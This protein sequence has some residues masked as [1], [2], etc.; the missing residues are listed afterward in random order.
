[1]LNPTKEARLRK[2]YQKV[3]DAMNFMGIHVLEL[4]RHP[5]ATP[6]QLTQAHEAYSR[7]YEMWSQVRF[8]LS[9]KYPGYTY[10]WSYK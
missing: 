1:M 7:A 5:E 8:R 10:P 2:V 4:V 6:E 9:H 3:T